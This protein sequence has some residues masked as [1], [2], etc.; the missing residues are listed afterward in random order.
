MPRKRKG[1]SD[2]S[3]FKKA[4]PTAMRKLMDDRGVTQNALADYIGKTRQAVSYYCDGS[5]SPDWET[6]AKIAEFFDVSTDYLVGRT[7][8]PSRLPCAVD[9]LGLSV[10]AVK[11]L[12]TI[13]A[14]TDK[15]SDTKHLSTL[16]EMSSFQ[17]LLHSLIEFF[18]ALKASSVCGEIVKSMG[19]GAAD[20]YPA[21]ETYIEKLRAATQ[22]PQ[23]DN[24]VQMYLK[25]ICGFEQAYMDSDM[26]YVLDDDE[27]GIDVL[28]ILELRINRNLSAVIRDIEDE[29]E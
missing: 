8:E 15:D 20:M 7:A 9:D 13:A 4:F 24:M 3:D 5:S 21:Q 10:D 27:D 17:T 1:Q 11:W 26:L 16:M 23:Y 29:F 14:S 12:K 2:V 18:S 28:D 22:D 25:A 6:L 19:F